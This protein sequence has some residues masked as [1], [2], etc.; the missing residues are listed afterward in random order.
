MGKTRDTRDKIVE[1]QK[2]GKRYGTIGK[3]LGENKQLLQL[4]KAKYDC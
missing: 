2:A 3:Q 1:I 4:G